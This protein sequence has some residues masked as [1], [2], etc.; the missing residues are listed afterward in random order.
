MGPLDPRLVRRAGAVRALLAVDVVLGVIAALLVLAQ[1]VLIATVAARA[2]A[3]ATLDELTVPLVLLVAASIGRAAAASGFEIVGRRAAT[4][5]LATLRLELVERRLRDHPAALDGAESAEVATAAVGGVD[6]LET[7]FARYLPQVVLAVTV[8]VAV[9]V[10]RRGD[11]PHLRRGDA[12]DTAAR[13]GVHVAR[14]PLHAAACP[15]AVA[16][17]R[18]ARDALPRRRARPADASRLQPR[19]GADGADRL[20]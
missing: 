1:A 9:L 6:A 7:T 18:A 20:R 12:V 15:R 8:P 3:G 10:L 17:A 2:F 14:R 11:R 16:D 4:D 5:V 19:R 13:A